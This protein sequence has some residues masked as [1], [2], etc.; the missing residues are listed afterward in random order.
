MNHQKKN[1]SVFVNAFARL[2]LGF[3][4]LNGTQGRRFGSLGLGLSAP[5]TLIEMAIGKHVFDDADALPYIAQS[6]N[7]L[8]QHAR[9]Q[10][11]VSIKVHREIPRHF[12]L[13]SGTQMA[14]AIGAGLNALFGTTL[15]ATEMAFVTGRGLRS[16]IGIGTFVDG[17]LVLDGGR[18]EQTQVPP[19][20]VQQAFPEPWSILLIFDRG[21]CGIHGEEEVQ[22]FARLSAADL[23][24]TQQVNHR[25]LMQALPALKERDLPSF[26]EGVAALQAYTGDYFA[27]M[28]GGRY[29]SK[30]VSQVLYDLMGQKV[31][32][33]GQS[34][35]GP[36]GFAI[37]ESRQMA[38]AHLDRLQGQFKQLDWLICQARNVGAVVS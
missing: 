11:E 25:V 20:L 29:A 32:C 19:I 21:Y 6:K 28:Q 16:G 18:G 31:Q 9:I 4:D 14:L 36:T 38:E 17:G 27:P 37:F 33:V 22:A 1:R 13:G 24:L 35:W 30:L 15:T 12:G 3:L 2:H 5:D 10:D 26:A 34:S 8:M 23:L 7:L